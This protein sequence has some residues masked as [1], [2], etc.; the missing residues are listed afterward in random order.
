MPDLFPLG[1]YTPYPLIF[2]P[3]NHAKSMKLHSFP[4]VKRSAAQNVTG[5]NGY[6]RG[7][8]VLFCT[9]GK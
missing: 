2:S 5:Q 3:Q 9:M 4:R 1:S 8:D 7:V 6:K